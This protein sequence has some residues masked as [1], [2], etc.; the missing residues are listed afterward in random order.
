MVKGAENAH[1]TSLGLPGLLQM[2]AR[3]VVYAQNDEGRLEPPSTQLNRIL[4]ALD[5]ALERKPTEPP[6]PIPPKFVSNLAGNFGI[7]LGGLCFSCQRNGQVQSFEGVIA[8]DAMIVLEIEM[9]TS[10]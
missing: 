5:A 7:T 8:G 4:T 1:P 10:A 9:L 3:V 6:P 2:N